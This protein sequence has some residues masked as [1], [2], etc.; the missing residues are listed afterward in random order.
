MSKN[1][2]TRPSNFNEYKVIS[3]EYFW[4]MNIGEED[5]DFYL[6]ENL[7]KD[8]DYR[9][10]YNTSSDYKKAHDLINEIY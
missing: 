3:R 6:L 7:K 4:K 8:Y 2:Y 10:G 1:K 9:M 5:Q